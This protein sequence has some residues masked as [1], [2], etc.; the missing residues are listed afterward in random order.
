MTENDTSGTWADVAS[1]LGHALGGLL[2]ALQAAVVIPGLLP[3]VVL[4]VVL[5][6]PFL[7]LGGVL[8]VLV[9]VPL[10]VVRL[11]SGMVRRR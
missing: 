9:A 11:A 2:L 4:T 7:V 6:L 3:A 8:A 1:V 5:V 10:G